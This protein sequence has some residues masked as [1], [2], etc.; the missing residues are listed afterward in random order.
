MQQTIWNEDI[1]MPQY[2]PLSGDCKT[3]VLIVGGGMCGCEL[4]LLLNENGH[5]STVLGRNKFLAPKECLSQRMHI[6]EWMDKNGVI[7]YTQTEVT[8]IT[9]EGVYASTPEGERFFPADT[10]VVSLGAEPLTEE[11]DKFKDTAFE[12]FNIGDCVKASDMVNATDTGNG[13]AMYI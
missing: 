10:V 1:K 5:K 12:V 7:A 11:R 3:D 8:R 4:G 9:Q 2:P 6:K 13:I